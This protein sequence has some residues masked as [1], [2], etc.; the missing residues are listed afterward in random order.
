MNYDDGISTPSM[1]FQLT[2][3]C[4]GYFQALLAMVAF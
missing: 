3:E 4:Q 1:E 2:M